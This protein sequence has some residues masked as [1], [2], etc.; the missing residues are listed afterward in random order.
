MNAIS[1][2]RFPAAQSRNSSR[3]PDDSETMTGQMMGRSGSDARDQRPNQR[4]TFRVAERVALLRISNVLAKVDQPWSAGRSRS[5][6]G[7]TTG[8]DAI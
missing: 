8:A 7:R 1:E 2:E 3:I 4:E 6:I 5:T